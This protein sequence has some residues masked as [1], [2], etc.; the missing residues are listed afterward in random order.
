MVMHFV[1]AATVPARFFE[2]S[3]KLIRLEQPKVVELSA[4]GDALLVGGYSTAIRRRSG[5]VRVTRDLDQH[6]PCPGL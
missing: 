1:R 3:L 5:R 2:G 4:T 6:T